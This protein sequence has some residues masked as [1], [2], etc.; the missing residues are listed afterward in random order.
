MQGMNTSSVTRI[1][2]RQQRGRRVRRAIEARRGLVAATD[3]RESRRRP[4]G[5][6]AWINGFE[7]GGTE[8]GHLPLAVQFD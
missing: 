4:R 2:E 1:S 8:S 3:I 5:G 7:L 6:R